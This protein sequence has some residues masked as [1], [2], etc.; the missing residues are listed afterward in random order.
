MWG[1]RAVVCNTHNAS[2]SF[3]V[4]AGAVMPLSRSHAFVATTPTS[5]VR[6]GASPRFFTNRPNANYLPVCH[7]RRHSLTHH[8]SHT[9]V[10]ATL[11]W[12]SSSHRSF[13]SSAPVLGDIIPFILTDVGEGI[14]ECEVQK[15]HVAAGDKVDEFDR[16]CDLRSDKASVEVTSRYK[17]KVTKVYYEVGQMAQVGAPLIDIELDGPDS[18]STDSPSV[19]APSPSAPAQ[20][21]QP[22]G[23][24]TQLANGSD[25]PDRI[26]LTT[27]A[28]RR[29]AREKNVDLNKVRGTGRG[30]RVMKEDVLDYSEGRVEQT[31]QAQQQQQHT[32][33][34]Q[35]QQQH[36]QQLTHSPP[37]F[38]Q[39]EAPITPPVLPP[40]RSPSSKS[41]WPYVSL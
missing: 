33:H 38:V 3:S 30:G 24:D 41:R 16:V 5:T 11:P 39:A 1:R 25:D 12:N 40:G 29:L 32:Q 2:S 14:A 23:I 35:Q 20:V 4:R 17:G 26:V 31:Q 34:T 37:P 8:S 10:M 36:T 13:H 9:T 19:S 18:A 6:A 22:V 21:A 7:Y 15:W 28:V 27:P